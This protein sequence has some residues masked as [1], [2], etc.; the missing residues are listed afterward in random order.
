MRNSAY[1]SLF[2]SRNR[3]G[4]PEVRPRKAHREVG[5]GIAIDNEGTTTIYYRAFMSLSICSLLRN[6]ESLTS[7]V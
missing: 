2:T 5:K 4:R 6:L 7:Y 1:D 3:P